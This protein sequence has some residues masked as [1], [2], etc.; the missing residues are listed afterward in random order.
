MANTIT[1]ELCAEDRA[2]LDAI[3]K[4]LQSLEVQ[5][6][7]EITEEVSTTEPQEAPKAAETVNTPP[8]A[9]KAAEQ[10][11]D[12]P[13]EPLPWAEA[14]AGKGSAQQITLEQ[15][16]QKVTQLAAAGNAQRKVKVRAVI[17][18]YAAKVSD[19][20][21]DKYAEVWEQL[22]RIEREG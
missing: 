8:A 5:T 11:Q 17:Q 13:Q 2:R 3:I 7:I 18:A 1:I 6:A 15:I 19:L 14:D 20:P 4:A 10:A 22:Q 12:A 9:E 16:R 21:A